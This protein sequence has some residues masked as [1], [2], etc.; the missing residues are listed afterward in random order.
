[1]RWLVETFACWVASL[2]WGLVSEQRYSKLIY[3]IKTQERSVV[4]VAWLMTH[5][6]VFYIVL[7]P[8]QVCLSLCSSV[9]HMVY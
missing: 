7:D 8:K 3:A 2:G 6:L 4:N 5:T 1:M 9:I